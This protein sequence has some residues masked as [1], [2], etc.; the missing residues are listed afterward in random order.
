MTVV[1]NTS[2]L[3]YLVLINLQDILPT[4][5]G[6]VLIPEAVRHELR[7]PVAPQ[8]VKE[9]LDTW[10]GWLDCRA[11]SR[12]PADL[13]QLDPGEQEA[14]ALAQALGASLILLDDRK[15][16]QAA[17]NLG[18]TVSGTLGV[19]D[20]A[21]RR[22]LADLTDALKRLERTSFRATPRLLRNIQQKPS[23]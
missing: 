21:A 18:L 15:G 1:S 4:L 11:V 5:F 19:L 7:S 22:G 16:R 8:P 17:R 20:L 12:V 6:Q 14:I 3:N 13:Q 10:P 9:F 23:L 2:P